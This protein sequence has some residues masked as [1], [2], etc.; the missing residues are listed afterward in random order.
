TSTFDAFHTEAN[1][2]D[3]P[4]QSDLSLTGTP[5]DRNTPNAIPPVSCSLAPNPPAPLP[6]GHAALRAP[7]SRRPSGAPI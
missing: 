2:T 6:V 3:T 5:R 4:N 7:R 1:Q